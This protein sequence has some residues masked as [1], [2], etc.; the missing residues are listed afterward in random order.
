MSKTIIVSNRLPVKISKSGDEYTSAASEGGLA[1]GLGS[2]YK[3]GNNKWIGWPGIEVTEEKDRQHITGQLEDLSLVPVFLDQEEIN[4]YYEGFSNDILWPIFHYYTSTYSVYKE[5]N[6]DYY[7]IVNEKFK[8][9]I[10]AIAEPGDV[11]WIHDYQLML[12]P[13]LVRKAM[14]DVSIGFFLHIPFPSHEMFRLIPW[15]KELLEGMLG[16]DLIGFHTFDDVRHFLG[17]TTR[18]LP[19]TS[20]ANVITTG[21]RSIVVESF[22]MGIDNQKYASLP[23][24]K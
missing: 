18:I 7:N 19:V 1:T 21:D 15:R 2:I 12:L 4:Q 6:W 23:L 22:P 8:D 17:A 10:L 9:A 20:S 11:I 13:Q 24:E 3:K 14:P 5:S 16:A